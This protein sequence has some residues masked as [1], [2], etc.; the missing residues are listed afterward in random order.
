MYAVRTSLP[1]TR[2]PVIYPLR[3]GDSF[4]D[5]ESIYFRQKIYI[6][7]KCNVLKSV[8]YSLLKYIYTQRI[9]F[10][11]IQEWFSVMYFLHCRFRVVAHYIGIDSSLDL[12]PEFLD[13]LLDS[14]VLH[15]FF[16]THS[17]IVNT[18]MFYQQCGPMGE[19]IPQPWTY[20]KK[21]MLCT[22]FAWLQAHRCLF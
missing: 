3:L 21:F 4:E 15:I 10:Q 20:I 19:F 7:I 1:R 13:R 17:L 6:C 2:S 12:G 22:R 14:F 9:H 18:H 5:D 16:T 11:M 8:P